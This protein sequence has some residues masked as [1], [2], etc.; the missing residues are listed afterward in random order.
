[1]SSFEINATRVPEGTNHY[2]FG[3]EASDIGLMDAFQGKITLEVDLD[4]RGRQFLVSGEA[5]ANGRFTCDRCL[6]AFD[7]ET[8]GIFRVLLIPE[9]VPVTP[10]EPDDEIRVLPSESLVI[11]L[12]EDVRQSLRLAVPVKLLCTDECKGLCPQCGTNLNEGQCECESDTTD[13]RWEPLRKL[14]RS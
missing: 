3:A 4:R 10:G 9:G 2:S 13:P 11:E 6:T 8:H 12:D 7:Q 5:L 14:S 1:M